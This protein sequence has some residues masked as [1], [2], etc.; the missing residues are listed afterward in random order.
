MERST[1]KYFDQN[2]NYQPPEEFE[3]ITPFY[4]QLQRHVDDINDDRTREFLL[5]AI[6]CLKGGLRRAAIVL[7]WQGAYYVL[8]Q[9]AFRSHLNEFNQAALKTNAIKKNIERIEQ[10]QRLKESETLICLEHCGMIS[11]SVKSA[12]EECLNRRNNCGHPNDYKI[13]DSQVAAH[14]ESLIVHVFEA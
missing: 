9:K 12:L 4:Q 3:L 10:F 2:F 8:V 14:I 1:L 7:S 6:A 13:T 11:K 5:E